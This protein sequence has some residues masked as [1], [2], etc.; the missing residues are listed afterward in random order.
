MTF[1]L[2]VLTEDGEDSYSLWKTMSSA[3]SE[4]HY[5]KS[6][7]G[8]SLCSMDIIPVDAYD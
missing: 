8:L 2:L 4:M 7:F 5:L 3:V 6:K 1:Y